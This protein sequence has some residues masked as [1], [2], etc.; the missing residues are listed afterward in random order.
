MIKRLGRLISKF[1][2]K[3]YIAYHMR[4]RQRIDHDEDLVFVEN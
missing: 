4:R 3:K 1:E 2:K